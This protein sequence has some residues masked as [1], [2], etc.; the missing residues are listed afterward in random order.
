MI[1][2]R[3]A[4]AILKNDYRCLNIFLHADF[5]KRVERAVK[6]YGVP[7]DKAERIVKDTD[8]ARAKHY[9]YYSDQKWGA[10]NNYDIS[11]N[12][13]AFSIDGAVQILADC[14]ESMMK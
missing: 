12:M 6:V 3:C 5:D 10:A 8:K 11:M 2:G 9:K 7:A 4:D 1:V 13:A 14:V